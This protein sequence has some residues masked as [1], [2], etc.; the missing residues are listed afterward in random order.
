[1]ETPSSPTSFY[2]HSE[3]VPAVLGVSKRTS[4]DIG[5]ISSSGKDDIELQEKGDDRFVV[6]ELVNQ[7]GLPPSASTLFTRQI[8]T[9][10]EGRIDGNLIQADLNRNTL[11][12]APV[13]GGFGAWSFVSHLFALACPTR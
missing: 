2:S 11:E 7:Q 10:A 9:P 5:Y 4:I 6:P 3:Y 12:L 13:D 1:M 8:S